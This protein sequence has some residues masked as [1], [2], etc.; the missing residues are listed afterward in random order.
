MTA[1]KEAPL[2]LRLYRAMR[3]KIETGVWPAGMRLR[4][5]RA[6]AAELGVSKFTV[7]RVYSRL[8]SEGYIVAKNRARFTV[9]PQL[10]I[11]QHPARTQPRAKTEVTYRYDLAQSGMDRDG[12]LF[13]AWRRSLARVFRDE[14]RLLRY[15]DIQGEREL[16]EALAQ[17][18][19]QA[20]DTRAYAD[21][22]I[23]GSNTQQLLRILA[24]LLQTE[25]GEVLFAETEFPLGVD[26]M[27]DA[28]FTVRMLYGGHAELLQPPL[29]N[30]RKRILYVLPSLAYRAADV[31]PAQIRAELLSW[32]ERTDGLIIEDDFDS[33][34]SYYGAPVASLQGMGDGTRVVYIGA[35]SKVLPPSL[36]LAYM[37]LPPDLLQRFL[38]RRELYRQTASVAEQLAL[39]DF[40][41]RGHFTR[42][43]RR[44]R[45]L[46]AEKGELLT[47]ALQQ[48]FGDS[49]R[50][51]APTAGI[52]L[53]V[54]VKT[55]ASRAALA[56]AA[57][58]RGLHLRRVKPQH[59]EPVNER[60]LLLSFG[61]I[62]RDDIPD[63]S[64]IL[65]AAY[66]DA[67][68]EA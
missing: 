49:I 1:T 54:Y 29:Q 3:E 21:D 22:I 65:Y 36:R 10:T 20:R 31:M 42:Q 45:K 8:A 58:R 4:S 15:G 64:R 26:T 27:S 47:N 11:R 6:Q 63:V 24:S 44:L 57:A 52:Y 28:G 68:K 18:G 16:R 38:A 32:S 23:I 37:I 41:E 60:M 33:E 34:L 59:N 35:L 67:L 9:M 46:Y 30:A 25:Y 7:E 14:K 50:I 13:A 39:A 5:V 53:P 12:F 2:Y 48:T 40:I 62:E 51:D 43:I 61:E 56:R 66:Q 17:Y 55:A 19:A